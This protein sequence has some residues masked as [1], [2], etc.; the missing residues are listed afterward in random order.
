MKDND[1]G[2]L[3]TLIRLYELYDEHR[4]SILWF[5]EDLDASSYQEYLKKYPGSSNERTQFVS[6]CGFFELSG[7]II[8]HKLMDPDLYF[9]MF[10]PT[11][12]WQKAEPIIKG[13]RKKRPYIYENFE[14]L[15]NKRLSWV[16]RRRKRDHSTINL[17]NNQ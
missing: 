2:D 12:F 6:V 5:L 9:D 17:A 16:K 13:I 1:S 14:Y 4:H 15:T 8:K 3:D 11:P 7:T 10:N